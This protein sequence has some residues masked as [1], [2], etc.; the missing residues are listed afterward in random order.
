MMMG[1]L[2]ENVM[3]KNRLIYRLIQRN[4]QV[5]LVVLFDDST[6]LLKTMTFD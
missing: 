6:S 2:I 1:K 3:I 5:S 4:Y